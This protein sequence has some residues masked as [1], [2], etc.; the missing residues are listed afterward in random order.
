[1]RYWSSSSQR[2]RSCGPAYSTSVSMFG[3]TCVSVSMIRYPCFIGGLLSRLRA[4]VVWCRSGG[5]L[6]GRQRCAHQQELH[7]VV[8]DRESV[9]VTRFDRGRV[10]LRQDRRALAVVERHRAA[11]HD[12]QLRVVVVVG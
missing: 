7:P 4:W 3:P 6:R 9:V 1:M 5:E 10:V 12:D 11:Q 2:A 8:A